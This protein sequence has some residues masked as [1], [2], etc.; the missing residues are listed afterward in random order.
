M[1]LSPRLQHIVSLVPDEA[2]LID[3]AT[4]HA[5]VAI[6]LALK[7]SNRQIIAS[8]IAEAPLTSGIRNAQRYDVKNIDFRLGSGLAVLRSDEHIDVAIL[9]GIGGHLMSNLLEGAPY[10]IP[11]YI[12]QPNNEAALVRSWLEAH[13]YCVSSDER[14]RDDEHTYEIF[15]A[16]KRTNEASMYADDDAIREAQFHFGPVLER[17]YPKAYAQWVEQTVEQLRHIQTEMSKSTSRAVLD[18]RVK[19]D[20]LIAYGTS[21]LQQ[22]KDR[23]E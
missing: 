11:C 12:L 10:D 5:Y 14:I 13:H 9:S 6:T 15:V 8:D 3:V 19:Y 16:Q 22:L 18:A 20:T 2:T 4:D 7:N 17:S 21:L 1:K 23:E